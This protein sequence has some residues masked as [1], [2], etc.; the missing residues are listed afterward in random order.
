MHA[1]KGW[2]N[3]MTIDAQDL[4]NLIRMQHGDIP[5][6]SVDL[7]HHGQ[8]NL[9][10]ILNERIIFRFA[11]YREGAVTVQR[12][13]M[14]LRALHRKL[15]LPTPNPLWSWFDLE[16]EPGFPGSAWFGYDA[17]PGSPLSREM[18]QR[19]APEAQDRLIGSL[20]EFLGG[21]HRVPVPREMALPQED[22]RNWEALF[23]ALTAAVFPLISAKARKQG[24]AHFEAGI[25]LLKTHGFLPTLI[26]GDFG[27]SNILWD[28]GIQQVTGIIDWDGIAVGDPAIDVAALVASYGEGIVRNHLA[29]EENWWPRVLFYCGTFAWQEA[30]FGVQHHD[31]RALESGLSTIEKH[32][33]V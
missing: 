17:L 3:L 18:L 6:G 24:R 27:S 20:V 8:N 21:L 4:L 31:A 13:A 28:S 22:V 29:D 9:V 32:L 7:V 14:M 26:H 12:T 30:L 11:R 10:M 25:S 2:G 19:L 1:G 23:Q 15:P 33:G 5:D 16:S